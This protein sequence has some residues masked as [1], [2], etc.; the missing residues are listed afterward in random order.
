MCRQV[1]V[2]GT[3]F[4]EQMIEALRLEPAAEQISTDHRPAFHRHSGDAGRLEWWQ[5]QP[6]MNGVRWFVRRRDHVVRG[7]GIG[8]IEGLR[9]LVL[10]AYQH[11]REVRRELPMPLH[12]LFH[13]SMRRDDHVPSQKVT[14]NQ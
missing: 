3:R 5:H 8:K 7:A 2:L 9:V 11:G 13:P 10:L 6:T 12:C 4:C 1:R 14:V